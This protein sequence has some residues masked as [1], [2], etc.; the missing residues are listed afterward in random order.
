MKWNESTPLIALITQF[1]F[2]LTSGCG[3][4]SLLAALSQRLRGRI[5]SEIRF[6]GEVIDRAGMTNVSGFVPQND[7]CVDGLTVREHF[8]FMVSCRPRNPPLLI[9][10]LTDRAEAAAAVKVREILFDWINPRQVPTRRQH[11][12]EV[13]VGRRE[14][15]A[16]FGERGA[17][18]LIINS[19]NYVRIPNSCWPSRAFSSATSRRLAWTVLAPSPWWTLCDSSPETSR[20]RNCSRSRRP[21]R[22]SFSSPF[23]NRPRTSSIS[24]PTSSWWMPGESSSTDRWR[25]PKR[26]STA[27]GCTARLCTTPPSSTSIKFPIPW[28]PTMLWSTSERVKVQEMWRFNLRKAQTRKIQWKRVWRSHGAVRWFSFLTEPRWAFSTIPDIISSSCSYYLW[29]YFSFFIDDSISKLLFICLKMQKC[30]HTLKD[31]LIMTRSNYWERK[32][33]DLIPLQADQ[34]LIH[35]ELPLSCD[36]P[37][38]SRP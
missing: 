15:E 33:N 3:K 6:N 31:F 10:H 26:C 18:P 14:A 28:S 27:S 7:V 37:C 21:H 13:F 25:K 19:I 35:F 2:H 24:S 8:Y 9:V 22:A 30:F 20:N 23:I 36:L 29:V 34:Y 32:L 5:V 4:T 38:S 1:Y 16:E 12:F 17:S 11:E